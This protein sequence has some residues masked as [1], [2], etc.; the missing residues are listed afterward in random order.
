MEKLRESRGGK[1]SMGGRGPQPPKFFLEP[2][3][4][5]VMDMRT[6]GLL[7]STGKAQIECVH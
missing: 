6:V 4:H 1:E 3:N 7:G 5:P 2:R